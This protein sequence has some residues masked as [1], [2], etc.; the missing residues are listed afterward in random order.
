[1]D[2]IIRDLEGVRSRMAE[3]ELQMQKI[4]KLVANPSWKSLVA[5]VQ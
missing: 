3:Y 2:V 4:R 5:A 1:M